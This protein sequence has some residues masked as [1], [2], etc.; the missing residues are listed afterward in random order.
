M[1]PSDYPSLTPVSW[2]GQNDREVPEGY[3]SCDD[4]SSSSGA[5]SAAAAAVGVNYQ[6][7]RSVRV[8]YMYR[9]QLQPDANITTV[10]PL[11]ESVVND[12]VLDAACSRNS[13]GSTR[14]YHHRDLA[15][16]Y[17]TAKEPTDIPGGT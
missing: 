1:S 17:A 12:V 7:L 15:R 9:L 14:H 16:A 3:V 11:I 13:D 6:A 10:V 5:A 4:W 8:V 2:G